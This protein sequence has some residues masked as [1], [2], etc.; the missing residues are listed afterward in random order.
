MLFSFMI[1]VYNVDKY[2]DNCLQSILCQNFKDYE[3]ILIDDGSTDKSGSLCDIYEKKYENIRV[4]HQENHGIFYT[5][6]VGFRA[7]RGEYCISV[8]SDDFLDKNFLTTLYR[9]IEKY[10]PDMI[11]INALKYYEGAVYQHKQPMY[12][13]NKFFDEYEKKELYQKLLNREMSNT[14]W[15]KVIKKSIIDS[16]FDDSRCQWI[17]L[18][19]D[20]L[21]S[22]PILTNAKSVLYLSAPLYYYRTNFESLTQKYNLKNYESIVEVNKKLEEYVSLWDI[23]RGKE[24]AAGRFMVDVYD[25]FI[26]MFKARKNFDYEKGIDEIATSG[27][28]REKYSVADKKNMDIRQRFAIW[29]IYNKNKLGM[30]LSGMIV[31][32]KEWYFLKKYFRREK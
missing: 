10:T 14:L 21:M 23:S 6:R 31:K 13:E 18:G 16:E 24:L 32:I 8:D 9:A 1:P 2:L 22:L 28:F 7:A 26:S 5:R 12:P 20:L 17:N 29:S 4:I 27:Y 19:E 15:T 11:V 25:I 3:I 30:M